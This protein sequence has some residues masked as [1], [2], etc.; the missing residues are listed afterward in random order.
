MLR[1]KKKSQGAALLFPNRIPIA[2]TFSLQGP[3]LQNQE[4]E[5]FEK[6]GPFGFILFGRNIDNPDQLKNLCDELRSCVG[7]ECPILIDQEGGRVQR[8]KEPHWPQYPNMQSVANDLEKHEETIISIAKDLSEV[9]IDVNC[10]PCDGC[11]A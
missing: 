3:T 8:M 7:W 2:A 9:G 1:S 4:I 6:A 11:F 10:A 5:L